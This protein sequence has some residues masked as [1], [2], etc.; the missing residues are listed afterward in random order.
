MKKLLYV[1]PALLLVGFISPVLPGNLIAVFEQSEQFENKN[2]IKSAIDVLNKSYDNSSY[3]INLRLGYL[4][5]TAKQYNESENYYKKAIAINPNG[6]EARL[7][8]TQPASQLGNTTELVDEYTKVLQINPQNSTAN[9]WMGMIYYNKKDYTNALSYFQ[10]VLDLYPFDYGSMLMAGWSKYFLGKHADAKILF[11]KVLWYVKGDKSASQGIA[12]ITDEASSV[13]TQTKDLIPVFNQSEQLESQKD[14][15]GAI[16]TMLKSYDKSSYEINLRLGWLNYQA[17]KYADA[18]KYYKTAIDLMPNSIE[19]RLGYT[20]VLNAQNNIDGLIA[21]Y[22]KIL[23]LDPQ[24]TT[25]NYFM[26][27]VYYN[28][29]D[30]KTAIT[31]LDKVVAMYPFGYDGLSLDAWSNYNLGKSAEARNMFERVLL[32]TPSD[33]DIKDALKKIGQ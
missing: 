4:Y 18:E 17:Q 16:S 30:Y 15:T 21:Q 7:Y 33:Q 22:N 27:D 1:F 24:N 26:G 28:K 3:E 29:K 23:A 31:Y 5:Y 12:M 8:I 11:Q 13:N 2:D 9:Y 20:Y 25:A 19:A 10:K 32:I 14:Y 6:V